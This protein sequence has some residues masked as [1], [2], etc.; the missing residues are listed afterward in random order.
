MEYNFSRN[1]SS[2]TLVDAYSS[3][4]HQ[5]TVFAIEPSFS[6]PWGGSLALVNSDKFDTVTGHA[7]RSW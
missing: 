7:Q 6:I 3:Y 5:V 4:A 2:A 1:N